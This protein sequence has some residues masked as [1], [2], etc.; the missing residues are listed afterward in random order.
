MIRGQGC[1][2]RAKIAFISS[3]SRRWDTSMPLQRR[4]TSGSLRDASRHIRIA[5]EWWGIIDR[6]NAVSPIVVC[7][8]MSAKDPAHRSEEH[9]SELQSLMR[10]S[11]AVYCLKKINSKNSST[12]EST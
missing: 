9:T 7:V 1:Y 12:Y 3:I 11:Y 2:L 5:P 10:T 8:R 4:T 6:K